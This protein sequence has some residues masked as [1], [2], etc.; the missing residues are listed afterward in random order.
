MAIQR[1]VS[2]AVVRTAHSLFHIPYDTHKR[3]SVIALD[4]LTP[5][6]REA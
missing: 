3:L 4:G 2:H 1:K 5:A 6:S